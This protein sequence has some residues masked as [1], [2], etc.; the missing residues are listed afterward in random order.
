M[1]QTLSEALKAGGLRK[2]KIG[3]SGDLAS[4]E[5]P[6]EE[7]V[8]LM[9]VLRQK[10]GADSLDCMTA[11]DYGDEFELVYHAFS[12]ATAETF[13]GKARVPRGNP[14]IE[15]VTSVYPA[16]NWFE[17]EVFDMFGVRFAGHPD[18]R[19]L[20]MYDG[21]EGHPLRKSYPLRKEQP[22][23]PIGK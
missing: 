6:A 4:V 1:S 10:M 20:L 21:F 13:V 15:S 8:E 11:V 9:R 17:R 19:R 3:K 2:A 14:V 7:I 22:R 23:L 12:Y 5:V 18:L 16:A